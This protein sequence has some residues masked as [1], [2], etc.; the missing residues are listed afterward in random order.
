MCSACGIVSTLESSPGSSK[1]TLHLRIPHSLIRNTL[2]RRRNSTHS[3]SY[4]FVDVGSQPALDFG[5]GIMFLPQPELNT[6]QTP[7]NNVLVF[8]MFTVLENTFEQ[9]AI[10]KRTAYSVATHVAFWTAV[11]H[12]N[13]LL[14]IVNRPTLC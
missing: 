7:P 12:D 5:V 6:L 4:S 10:T 2:S 8:D 11:T 13:P 1:Q 3:D 9:I 14:R